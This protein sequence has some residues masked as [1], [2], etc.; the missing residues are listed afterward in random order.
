MLPAKVAYPIVRWKNVLLT[1]GFYNLSRRAPGFVKTLIRKGVERHLP[2]GYDVDTHFKPRYDPWDQRICLV[3]DGDLFQRAA[4]GTARRSS[5]TASRRS[6]RRGL[7]LESGAELEADVI[8]TATGL[9]LLMLGGMK[10]AVDGR[11]VDLSETVALQGHDVRRRAEPGVCARL[12]ERVVDAQVRPRRRVRLPAAE[13]HGRARLRQCTPRAPDPSLA[14]AAVH[15]PQVRV[16]CCAR[17]TRFPSRARRAPWRLHQ[18]YTRDVRMLRRGALQDGAMEFSTPPAPAER[19]S[20][21]RS[22]MPS[23]VSIP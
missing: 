10:I 18:N 20:N 5:P 4:Q 9:N 1:T 13:P 15:R 23:M 14:D 3:P 2:E 19:H 7:K 8:V 16:T 12:H 17:S 6:P 22:V 21:T 11:E